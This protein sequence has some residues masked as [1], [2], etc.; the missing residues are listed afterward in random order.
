MAYFL[1]KLLFLIP[2]VAWERTLR[3]QKDRNCKISHGND[4]QMLKLKELGVVR[5]TEW[6]LKGVCQGVITSSNLARAA[7]DP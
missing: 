2:L 5:K 1:C 4:R 6:L 7:S 3:C